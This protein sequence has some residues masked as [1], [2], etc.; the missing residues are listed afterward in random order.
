LSQLTEAELDVLYVS[1]LRQYEVPLIA[2]LSGSLGIQPYQSILSQLE[3]MEETK[4]TALLSAAKSVFKDAGQEARIK[5]QHSTGFLV[6]KLR[7]CEEPYDLIMLGKRGE[8]FE[9]AKEHIGSTIE[10]VVRASSKPCLV[11]SR[12]YQPIERVALAFDGGESSN[13]AL[14]YIISS[15]MFRGLEIHVVSVP[16]DKGEDFALQNL[17]NAED[18]LVEITKTGPLEKLVW[19]PIKDPDNEIKTIHNRTEDPHPSGC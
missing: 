14:N 4:A 15:N 16:D 19:A 3:E 5:T 12:A 18:Q 11:T 13:K 7:D 8:H 9:S 1:D 6:D 10:R 2:D 17:R